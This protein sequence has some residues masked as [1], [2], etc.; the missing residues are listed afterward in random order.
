MRGRDLLLAAVR[1][2]RLLQLLLEHESRQ[3]SVAEREFGVIVG[4]DL[5]DQTRVGP[6]RV[7]SAGR[8][9]V[10]HRLRRIG[11]GG[12][13]EAARAHAERVDA[14]AVDLVDQRVGGRGQVFVAVRGVVLYGVDETLRVLDAHAHCEGLGFETHAAAV[15]RVVDILGRVARGEHHGRALDR[16]AVRRHAAQTPALDLEARDLASEAYLSARGGDGAADVAYDARQTVGAD[17]GM[18]L[19]EDL[20][21]RAVEHERLQRLV[22]VAAFLAAREQFAVGEGARATLA[23]RI[24]RVGVDVQ[25][26][27]YEGYVLLAGQDLLAAFE[28]DGLEPQF[29]ESQ[30]GE[31]PRGA[32]ADHDHLGRAA[33]VGIVEV[34]GRRLRLAVDED[35][36]REVDL[37]GAAS[38][39]D[40]PLQY[41][42]QGHVVTFDA[43]RAGSE[44]R[45][46]FRIGGLLRREYEG[47]GFR[48]NGIVCGRSPSSR[49]ILPAASACGTA[50]QCA[51]MR[52]RMFI[53]QK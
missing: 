36:Q 1:A 8:H 38:R 18:R 21:R 31:E 37:H 32:R 30:R 23:E 34:H 14:A 45:V 51:L 13:D 28:Q 27:V 39:V 29:D 53:L 43:Q 50:W 25:I 15:E 42:R 40:G 6:L 46:E 12:H 20:G 3:G 10:H 9:A 2:G 26:A 4:A 22:V 5:R 41:A 48:H 24:V 44:R 49:C 52:D 16:I 35:L 17:M 7:S 11:H 19:E 47:Y 33:H